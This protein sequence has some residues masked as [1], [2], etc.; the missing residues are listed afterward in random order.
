M[1]T[2]LM[3]PLRRIGE[4]PYFIHVNGVRLREN[5]AY[6]RKIPMVRV[7]VDGDEV[8][9]DNVVI[10]EMSVLQ[11][12]YTH[13]MPDYPNALCILKTMGPITLEWDV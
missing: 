10:H 9:C 2:K 5:L 1:T 13:P 8:H 6:T 3:F 12:D 4:Q 11:T 7:V